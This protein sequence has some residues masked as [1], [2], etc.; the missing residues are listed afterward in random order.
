MLRLGETISGKRSTNNL[1]YACHQSVGSGNSADWPGRDAYISSGNKHNSIADPGNKYVNGDCLICHVPHG[2]TRSGVNDPA[3]LRQKANDLCL[4]CH[5][6]KMSATSGH[7]GNCVMCHNPHDVGASSTA[8]KVKNPAG[9]TQ[10]APKDTYRT[11]ALI[12]NTFCEGCHRATPPAGLG[13]AKDP[14]TETG[15]TNLE[16]KPDTSLHQVHARKIRPDETWLRYRGSQ[17]PEYPFKHDVNNVRCVTCHSVHQIASA[18]NVRTDVIGTRIRSASPIGYNGKA[19]CGS[20]AYGCHSCN[21]CHAEP[22]G[23]GD[24]CWNCDVHGDPTSTYHGVVY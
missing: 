7:N 2:K 14:A 6:N 8:A 13:A 20:L 10:L 3:M 5:T 4:G 11:Q 9:G 17:H 24:R 15:F 19:A 12:K 1:C 16:A 21:Y 22:G 23:P 18:Q